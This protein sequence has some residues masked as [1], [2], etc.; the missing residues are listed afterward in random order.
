MPNSQLHPKWTVCSVSC[1]CGNKFEMISTNGTTE[2]IVERCSKCH[3]AFTGSFV[4]TTSGGRVK[5][6]NDRFNFRKKS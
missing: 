5:R 4:L 3:Q 1:N 2:L 6:F